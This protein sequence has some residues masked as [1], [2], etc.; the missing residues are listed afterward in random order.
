MDPK[1]DAEGDH[2]VAPN[3]GL[4]L[5]VLA[6]LMKSATWMVGMLTD[7]ALE[8]D[9]SMGRVTQGMADLLNGPLINIV[10]VLMIVGGGLIIT[11]GGG[12]DARR[13]DIPAGASNTPR[14]TAL[15]MSD[16]AQS[17]EV[18]LHSLMAQ[19][20]AIPETMVLSEAG[21][22][23]E[24]I[25]SS[26]VPDLQNAHREA[27]ATVP[28]KSVK[29]DELDADYALSLGR[30]SDALERLIEGC[31]ALGRERLEVQVLVPVDLTHRSGRE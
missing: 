30:I 11:F 31:E 9:G 4:M 27:R 1:N 3:A 20:R 22:E 17:A 5:I 16:T 8:P 13:T 23:F 28:A 10:C 7:G 6:F 15:P 14:V 18:R 2:F 12:D 26:H 19:F 21:V 24:R 29:S 25:E